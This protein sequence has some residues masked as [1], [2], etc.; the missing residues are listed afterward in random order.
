MVEG[1]SYT[2][3]SRI[4]LYA[5]HNPPLL[6]YSASK[7]NAWSGCVVVPLRWQSGVDVWNY[8]FRAYNAPVTLDDSCS[9]KRARAQLLLRPVV[10]LDD[11]WTKINTRGK[12]EQVRT[13]L[14]SLTHARKHMYT[15]C[16]TDT[17]FSRSILLDFFPLF[18]FLVKALSRCFILYRQHFSANNE[19]KFIVFVKMRNVKFIIWVVHTQNPLEI[20]SARA[21]I[22][23]FYFIQL[24]IRNIQFLY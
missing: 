18:N 24:L 4:R 21:C 22:T 17:H 10:F 9:T 2:F 5:L 23:Y 14:H 13:F 11:I 3:I 15:S 16:F 7:A 19:T 1:K 12:S 6:I 20:L 8:A